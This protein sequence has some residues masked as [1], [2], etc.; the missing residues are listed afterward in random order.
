M[1]RW[2]LMVAAAVLAVGVIGWRWHVVQVR[3]V[4]EAT[5][6]EVIRDFERE[7]QAAT[8][9]R[10][11]E[12]MQGQAAANRRLSDLAEKAGARV[13][14]LEAE[15]ERFADET[16]VPADCVV[17]PDLLDRLWAD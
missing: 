5:R 8:A 7:V 17:G 11:A 3:A 12:K 1:I 6:A 13:A 16:P 2:A 10:L 14:A 4:V 9:R 15:L